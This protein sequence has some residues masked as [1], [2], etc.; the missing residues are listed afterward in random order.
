MY[1]KIIF[2]LHIYFQVEANPYKYDKH[3]ELITALRSEGDLEQLR[4]AR[5]SMANIYPL[6]EGNLFYRYCC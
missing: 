4:N 5:E 6:S 2:F 3:I 1:F